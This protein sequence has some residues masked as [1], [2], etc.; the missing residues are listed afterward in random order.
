MT[1][2]WEMFNWKGEP[3]YTYD[4]TT[5][6]IAYIA[7]HKADT[8][9]YIYQTPAGDWVRSTLD[10]EALRVVSSFEHQFIPAEKGGKKVKPLFL[11][12]MVFKLEK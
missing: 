11:Q 9:T 6:S 3:D 4:F 12:P 10:Q 8:A 5:G 7:P 2:K 1:G